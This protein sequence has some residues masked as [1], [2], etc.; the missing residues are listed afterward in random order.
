MKKIICMVL[1]AVLV[2]G[3]F[4]GCDTNE[5]NATKGS[6]GTEAPGVFQVGYCAVDIT[7]DFAVNTSSAGVSTDG[8]REHIFSTC[9]ALQSANTTTDRNNTED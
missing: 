1:C 5:S 4:A 3:L 9:I 2:A 7:P 8:A 6:A